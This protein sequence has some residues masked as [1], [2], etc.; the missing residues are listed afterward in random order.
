MPIMLAVFS[1]GAE[2]GISY[3]A[4]DL[5]PP[6]STFYSIA[7]GV[8]GNQVIGSAADSTGHMSAVLWTSGNPNPVSLNPPGSFNSL[9]FALLPGAQIGQV[10]IGSNTEAAIWDGTPSGYVT[11]PIPDGYNSTTVAAISGTQIV[12]TARAGSALPR[13]I[14]WNN[15]AGTYVPVDLTPSGYIDGELTGVENGVQVGTV[16]DSNNH[17]ALWTGSAASYVNLSP[18]G[19]V[20]SYA[21]WI[22]GGQIVGVATFSSSPYAPENAILWTG[23]SANCYVNL[24]GPGLTNSAALAAGDGMQ[25]G[26]GNGPTTGGR[27]HAIV[28]SSSADSYVDLQQFLPDSQCDQSVAQGIDSQGDIVGYVEEAN[29]TTHAVEWV[30]QSVPLPAGIW[31]AAGLLLVTTVVLSRSRLARR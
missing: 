1:S 8:S 20:N 17:A 2:A 19:S 10:E 16:G 26:Y 15:V 18:A 3:Q 5:T 25:V 28:W 21:N 23:P 14:L 7:S 4:I 6:G 30:P 11:L 24:N 12:G 22:G 9:G 27:T 31:P 29:G 13:A